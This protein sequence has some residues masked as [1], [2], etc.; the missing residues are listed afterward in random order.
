MLVVE[1]GGGDGADEELAAVG[2]GAGV[3]GLRF[4]ILMGICF[5]V[6]LGWVGDAF[7]E[8]G[9]RIGKERKG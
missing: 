4:V 7:G 2:V 6:G 1:E 3:L 8:G 9:G 5:V